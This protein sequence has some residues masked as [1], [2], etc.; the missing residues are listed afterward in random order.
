[1]LKEIIVSN[2]LGKSGLILFF[3][4]TTALVSHLILSSST[5]LV[6][7]YQTFRIIWTAVAI[8]A[9]FRGVYI[10]R[11][12]DTIYA[13][14]WDHIYSEISDLLGPSIPTS[15]G[16]TDEIMHSLPARLA[17][18]CPWRQT[19]ALTL[20]ASGTGA[21]FAGIAADSSGNVVSGGLSA[22]WLSASLSFAGFAAGV[23]ASTSATPAAAVS[24]SG[25]D[26]SPAT[27][28][29]AAGVDSA[30]MRAGA[31]AELRR[32]C[33]CAAARARAALDRAP[34]T[35]PALVSAPAPVL[36]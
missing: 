32:A 25:S 3:S 24:R 5:P 18:H 28:I 17:C 15:E 26:S 7:K 1:M 13:T 12:E 29:A 21:A 36:S 2:M 35:A 30:R 14:M 27:A 11:F 20:I 23:A 16:Q 8:T 10:L 19:A 9:A 4:H 31:L 34:L 33:V 22:P 6:F